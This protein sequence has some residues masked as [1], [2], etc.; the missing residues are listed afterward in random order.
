MPTASPRDAGPIS[1]T[2][3]APPAD[4]PPVVGAVLSIP[5]GGSPFPARP[6]DAPP[7]P[8][9]LER[10][11]SVPS[12][13]DVV[14]AWLAAGA[15]EGCVAVAD[16]QTA[17]RG[18]QGRRWTA[19]PGAA[20]LLSVGFRPAWL[21]A[22]RVWRLAGIVALAMA[23][24]AEDVAGLASGTIRLKWP[25]DL[26]VVVAGPG[27]SLG[28]TDPDAAAALA[29]HTA[30]L[31]IRKLAGI[32][33]ETDGLGTDDP[34]AV[35][36]IGI[37]ADWPA[38][39]FPAELASSMTSLGEVSGGRPID[40]DD[41][42]DAFLSR[43]ELRLAALRGGRFDVAGWAERQV[44]TGRLAQLE[45]H[46]GSTELVLATGV[47]GASGALLVVAP[48]DGPGDRERAIHAGEITHLRLAPAGPATAS[49][50]GTV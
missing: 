46:G 47:D 31:E 44:T 6:T 9:R 14:R 39:A 16:E 45:T 48:E 15:A 50:A 33:G 28:A 13:N 43:L 20:L 10:H 3:P 5:T 30:P 1:T 19:P 4:S 49:P 29:R 42:L 41:L 11:A 38:E 22:D 36:G 12:T 40:R 34:R 32:L 8:S 17:G 25:N 7:F 37:N 26:V 21:P 23:D 2:T 27:A 24:A 35:I 18:R